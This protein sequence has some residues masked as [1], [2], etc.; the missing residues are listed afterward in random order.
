MP[1]AVQVASGIVLTP[2]ALHPPHGFRQAI[3][4][5][6]LGVVRVAAGL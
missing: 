3:D 1:D 2:L 5:A 6:V 4:E